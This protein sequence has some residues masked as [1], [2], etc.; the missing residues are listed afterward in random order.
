MHTN[1]Q[2]LFLIVL[3]LFAAGLILTRILFHMRLFQRGFVALTA[4]DFARA[5]QAYRWA[6]TYYIPLFGPWP[7]F[8]TLI[9]G[10]FL[11]LFDHILWTPRVLSMATGIISLYP[12]FKL[13]ELLFKDKWT[14]SLAS[15]LVAF[16]HI[17]IWLSSVPLTEIYQILFVLF[18]LWQ[19]CAYLESERKTNLVYAGL[20][21]LLANGFRFEAWMV[22]ALFSSLVTLMELNRLRRKEATPRGFFTILAIVCIPWTFPVFWIISNYA[23]TGDPIYF[24]SFIRE[25]KDRWYGDG[26]SLMNYLVS[27]WYLDP[28]WVYLVFPAVV[29][30]LVRFRKSIPVRGYLYIV[31]ISPLIFL[32]LSG[33][34]AE[35]P[36]NYVRYLALF[37]IILY[38]AIAAFV[39]HISYLVR[40]R[41]LS[42]ILVIAFAAYFVWLQARM[43]LQIKNDPS[44]PY[45]RVGHRIGQLTAQRSG[46]LILV[47]LRR[48]DCVAIEAG[49]ND[50]LLLVFDRKDSS[51]LGSNASILSQEPGAV[52]DQIVNLNV[53]TVVLESAD[54]RSRFEGIFNCRPRETLEGYCFYDISDFVHRKQSGILT[55]AELASL[56]DRIRTS[57]TWQVEEGPW[58][59]TWTR[60][61]TGNT[62]DG[63]WVNSRTNQKVSDVL[64]VE[65]CDAEGVRIFR[66]GLGLRYY[67][68]INVRTTGPVMSG[69]AEWYDKPAWRWEIRI[70]E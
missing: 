10:L 28:I 37:T 59:G 21:L 5:L 53:G 25:Y 23:H 11:K 39:T 7:P 34:Q 1:K 16:S 52:I 31:V 6:H 65:R 30:V 18:F 32:M 40:V 8:F 14:A 4:D 63:F 2:R 29:F 15:F 38:P 19:F 33:G 42:A 64:T 12:T 56:V 27:F 44:A 45:L 62:F 48:W 9:N 61:E 24:I 50:S 17:H 36:G 20:S 69:S 68:K 46:G 70:L 57:T 13:A 51:L 41:T 22:S 66:K 35:T 43:T 3:L 55:E 49:S 47:E 67:G 60:R 58:I 54:L 26:G